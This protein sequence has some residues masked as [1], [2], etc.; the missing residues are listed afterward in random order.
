MYPRFE[1]LLKETGMTAY[2]VSQA[3]GISKATLSNWKNGGYTPKMD[4]IKIIAD[5]FEVS[6]EWLAGYD[7][8]RKLYDINV[9]INAAQGSCNVILT[10][11]HLENLPAFIQYAI[12]TLSSDTPLMVD[13]KPLNASEADALKNSLEGSLHLIKDTFKKYTD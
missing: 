12:D 10:P 4:K 9:E 13:K 2:Q 3:T 1:I 7:V 6:A 11:E 8:P 5:F